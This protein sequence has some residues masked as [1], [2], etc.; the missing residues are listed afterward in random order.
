MQLRNL[1]MDPEL[2]LQ[3]VGFQPDK[4]MLGIRNWLARDHD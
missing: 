3:V 1:N 2:Y 4:D